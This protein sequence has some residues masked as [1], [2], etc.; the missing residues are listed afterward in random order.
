MSVSDDFNRAD[1]ATLGAN[2]TDINLGNQIV[3]NSCRGEN[4]GAYNAS[5][6]SGSSWD[7]DH[8]SEA[9]IIDGTPDPADCGPLVR[10][11]AGPDYYYGMWH[12]TGLRRIYRFDDGSATLLANF[13]GTV[14]EGDVILLTATGST[15]EYFRNAGSLGTTSDGTYGSGSPGVVVNGDTTVGGIAS[16]VGT[17]EVAGGGNRRRRVILGAA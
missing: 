6:Y 17:G 16:W 1:A 11:A 15:L 10:G 2:W 7:D 4:N 8:G 14:A 5:I 3:G 13:D 12:A 9:T